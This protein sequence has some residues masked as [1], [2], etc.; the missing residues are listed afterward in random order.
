MIVNNFI[1]LNLISIRE[2]TD[3]ATSDLRGLLY[4]LYRAKERIDLVRV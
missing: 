1:I 2:R 4:G 3:E